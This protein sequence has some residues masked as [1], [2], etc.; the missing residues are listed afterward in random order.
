MC[1]SPPLVKEIRL[2]GLKNFPLEIKMEQLE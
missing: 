1:L 2:Q